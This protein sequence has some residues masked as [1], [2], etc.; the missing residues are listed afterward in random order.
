MNE[1][2]HGIAHALQRLARSQDRAAWSVLMERCGPATERLARRLCSDTHEAQDALQEA[3]LQIRDGAVRFQPLGDDP[4][5]GAWG[6][7][8]RVTANA[9]LKWKRR[10]RRQQTVHF[11]ETLDPAA[12]VEDVPMDT[13]VACG[14]RQSLASLPEEQR[15]AVVLHVVE[16]LDFATLAASFGCTVAAAKMRVYRGIERLRQ[17]LPAT[18]LHSVA[19]P[20]LL[21]EL[22]TL[23]GRLDVAALDKLLTSPAT[24]T[25]GAAP[26]V[27]GGAAVSKVVV[28]GA[29]AAV[30]S[31]GAATWALVTP[32][33][34]VITSDQTISA[35]LT[36]ARVSAS[37]PTLALTVERA[38]LRLGDPPGGPPSTRIRVRPQ[39]FADDARLTYTWRQV[40][41]PMSPTAVAL[42]PGNAVRFSHTSGEEITAEFPDRGVYAIAVSARDQHG[43]MRERLTW[44]NVW[45]QRSPVLMDGVP[46]ALTVAPGL[47]PPPRVRDLSP[48]PGPFHH[49][50]LFCTVADWPELHERCVAG[51]GRL[52]SAAFRAL[53]E[54]SHALLE[55]NG[56]DRQLLDSLGA[57]AD[58]TASAPDLVR[59]RTP[60]VALADLARFSTLLADAALIEWLTHDPLA[61]AAVGSVTSS[62]RQLA[63]ALAGLG[64]ALLNA[65]WDREHSTFATAHPLFPTGFE[66]PGDPLP[67][68]HQ[69]PGLAIA[70]DFLAQR[71]DDRQQQA[72]RDYL[73]ATAAGRITGGRRFARAAGD[74]TGFRG[75]PRG[76]QQLG[77]FNVT[78]E[79]VIKALV[80]A[81]EE[82]GA[83][84]KVVRAFLEPLLPGGAKNQATAYDW[85]RP[86]S[87]D[88]GRAHPASRPYGLGETWP[89]ARKADVD[90]LQRSIW[91]HQDLAITPWGTLT[92]GISSFTMASQW[93]WPTA[94]AF[95]RQG[96][97]NQFV[98]G[99]FYHVVAHLLHQQRLSGDAGTPRLVPRRESISF[100]EQVPHLRL[101]LKYMY[102]DDPA[103][104]YLAACWAED[105]GRAPTLWTCL[106]GI[107]PQI[108]EVRGALAGVATAKGL[109]LTKVDP[110]AGAVVLRSDWRDD[111]LQIDLDAGVRSSIHGQGTRNAFTLV[112][113]GRTWSGAT[114]GQGRSSHVQAGIQVQHPAWAACPVT[115]GF[116]GQNPN[117][118]PRGDAPSFGDPGQSTPSGR[119][120][121]WQEASDGSWSLAVG[122]ASS[123][124]NGR[125]DG[126]RNLTRTRL[127][128][129]RHLPPGLIDDLVARNPLNHALYVQNLDQL[130]GGPRMGLR[131]SPETAVQYA[132]RSILLVR[133]KQPYVLVVD[134]FRKD[135]Q[136]WNHR[137]VMSHGP[138]TE[139]TSAPLVLDGEATTTDAVLRHARDDGAGQPRLLVRDLARTPAVGQS[140]VRLLPLHPA[141]AG[142][143]DDR[144]APGQ[145]VVIER[146]DV[147]DP[148]FIVL[149]VP[150]RAGDALPQ[151]QWNADG[152]VLT[153]DHGDGQVERIRCARRAGEVRTHLTVERP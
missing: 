126:P 42:T 137:W 14:I 76:T 87:H 13:D 27:G 145:Q 110:E 129:S 112:A 80:V 118:V 83:D 125:T 51:Q 41:D 35:P 73:I 7:I 77:S 31:L 32:R 113:L 101:L 149:L 132:L 96:A 127:D 78:D 69:L 150:H 98:T 91:W 134:D 74:P 135:G 34:P 59:G 108:A 22:P 2:R 30:V 140:P 85:T 17:Q 72:V 56:P 86:A 4:D 11:P 89:Y 40:A 123:A 142:L 65:W 122:D 61:P 53:R 128:W 151:T 136:P 116:L 15:S 71:M 52:A 143:P 6:W 28:A 144:P 81:G 121:A 8:M 63:R 102:P 25:L 104:D 21:L 114:Y 138:S 75:V 54:R 43:H 133:G 115:Q 88:G 29:L 146:R 93:Q 16:G 111:A 45:G 92:D 62:Q 58:G 100:A 120:V 3:W 64:T 66:R 141:L 36:P 94:L 47:R 20:A 57:Y 68:T 60:A 19:V 5:A 79:Q 23:S 49:P 12:P 105:L 148:G 46:D 119:L 82:S 26:A 50:R 106:F 117:H 97:N 67:T 55:G 48:D 95:A 109:P 152:T 39:G 107:D 1:D 130:Y 153:V 44:V 131:P 37:Q 9:C 70:Y 103:V 38:I 33:A 24:A 99:Y 18:A 147:V 90:N 10:E 139:A 124:Y 84:P